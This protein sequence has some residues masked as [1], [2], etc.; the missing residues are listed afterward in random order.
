MIPNNHKII[1]IELLL[2]LPPP[3][4]GIPSHPL[5]P[6]PLCFIE[7][8]NGLGISGGF[9]FNF[10][11]KTLS[12]SQASK[13]LASSPSGTRAEKTCLWQRCVAPWENFPQ[14][15]RGTGDVYK[16]YIYDIYI[17]ISKKQNDSLIKLGNQVYTNCN[18]HNTCWYSESGELRRSDQNLKEAYKEY[19][20]WIREAARS[21]V[22]VFVI[23][24]V[25]EAENLN[26]FV[27][28]K[29]CAASFCWSQQ[30]FGWMKMYGCLVKTCHF[31]WQQFFWHQ[32]S[33]AKLYHFKE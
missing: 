10:P 1:N 6:N 28:H 25:R 22:L 8:H 23:S 13:A 20:V 7:N 26:V 21:Y 24:H 31:P 14:D 4:V 15:K 29:A 3:K 32:N 30:W 12:I 19:T 33:K 17:Y 27:F 9:P 5:N 18:K 16:L 11:A 2:L